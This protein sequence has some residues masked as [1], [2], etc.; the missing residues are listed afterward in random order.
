MAAVAYQL[1]AAVVSASAPNE[2]S[3]TNYRKTCM[4]KL[5]S[6]IHKLTHTC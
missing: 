1:N 5:D 3:N 4:A 6:K 2:K